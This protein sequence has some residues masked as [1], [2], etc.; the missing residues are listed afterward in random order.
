MA[1]LLASIRL[2][3]N[4]VL[5]AGGGAIAHSAQSGLHCVAWMLLR[6]DMCSLTE[7]G[8]LCFNRMHCLQCAKGGCTQ[9]HLKEWVDMEASVMASGDGKALKGCPGRVS[10]QGQ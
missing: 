5:T 4:I 8:L 1:I 7:V 2:Q 9:N 3:L 10:Q 6:E